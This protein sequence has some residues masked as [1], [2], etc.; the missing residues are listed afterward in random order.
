MQNGLHESNLNI[1]YNTLG[2]SFSPFVHSTP[3]HNQPG[4][5]HMK[6]RNTCTHSDIPLHFS[7]TKTPNRPKGY[8][9]RKIDCQRKTKQKSA[10]HKLVIKRNSH[11]LILQLCKHKHNAKH[12]V[13]IVV[14]VGESKRRRKNADEK[15]R[16][17][18]RRITS[19]T[20]LLIATPRISFSPPKSHYCYLLSPHVHGKS[21][22]HGQPSRS[23]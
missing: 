4:Y 19:Q 12:T 11:R 14:K 17:R 15:I 13:A 2:Y 5:I 18:R 10:M 21:S 16:R 9:K 8:P 6:N 7:V 1:Q 3:T 20:P 23:K 22:F